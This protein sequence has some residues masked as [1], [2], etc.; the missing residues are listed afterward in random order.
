M[1]K[2]FALIIITPLIMILFSCKSQQNIVNPSKENKQEKSKEIKQEKSKEDVL[3]EGI[4]VVSPDFKTLSSKLSIEYDGNAFS[5]T[6]RMVKD[7]A[8]W[9]SLG[10]FG[11]EGVRVLLTKDSVM[12]LNKLNREYFLGG[13]EFIYDM[14]GFGLSYNMLQSILLGK[15]FQNY[16]ISDVKYSKQE[17]LIVFEFEKRQS[18]QNT[19]NFPQLKQ[20]IYFDTTLNV[21]N[22]NYF[23][24]FN[25][26]QKMDIYYSIYLP[27]NKIK[28]PQTINVLM[29]SNKTYK[30]NLKFE[31]QKLNDNLEIPFS[32][33]KTY[34]RMTL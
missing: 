26:K 9:L 24:L 33:P 34:S 11:I 16:G 32:I 17:N 22:R 3:L 6:M 25:S 7:S 8:I 19:Q 30:V 4:S 29:Y 12:M 23:E 18:K 15:D 13:Y 21:I 20:K 5:G 1:K 27:F 31:K 28:L 2:Y 10:K 14:L